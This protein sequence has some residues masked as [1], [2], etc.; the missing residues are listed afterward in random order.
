MV[1]SSRVARPRHLLL[2][3]AAQGLYREERGKS[4]KGKVERE[5]EKG[6]RRRE[7]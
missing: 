2:C 4:R 3:V 6:K 1:W 5:K 7:K